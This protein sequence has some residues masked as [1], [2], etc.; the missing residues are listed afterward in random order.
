MEKVLLELSVAWPGLTNGL[1]RMADAVRLFV[2]TWDP[3]AGILDRTS[4]FATTNGDAADLEIVI[5]LPTWSLVA[6][7]AARGS[8][9]G[10]VMGAMAGSSIVTAARHEEAVN[11]GRYPSLAARGGVP[12]LLSDL[13]AGNALGPAEIAAVSVEWEPIGLGAITDL[14]QHAYGPVDLDRS[15]VEFAAVT[16][17]RRGCPA[18]AGRRF[19]FPGELATARDALCP[20][21]LQR[22]ES[23]V[24]QRL[25]RANASNPAGWHAITD[26]SLRLDRPHL[27]NGLA[28][29]LP[30]ADASIGIIAAPDALAERA[31][32]VVEA[33]GW[34]RG[35][36]RDFTQALGQ[37]PALAGQ[38]PDWLANLI[39]DLGRAG[40]GSD[41]E[42][43][44]DALGQ[45]DPSEQASFDGDVCVALAE[46]GLADKARQRIAAALARWPDELWIRVN[47]GEALSALGDLQGAEEHFGAALRMTDASDDFEARADVW[48][49]LRMATRPAPSGPHGQSG[50][51]RPQ[52]K[53]KL[54]KAQRKRKR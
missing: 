46:S 28:S 24:N 29:R 13:E 23:L 54:S 44:G 6:Q 52:P 36:A 2:I 51:Q 43:V 25:A 49:R 11:A 17:A 37:E 4:G 53:R 30:S 48:H 26:A 41:A 8:T 42:R 3:L 9:F 15:P 47:A 32:A 10:A 18:C 35:R 50:G 19:G 27:P 22:A 39:L 5:Y 33:A 45:V 1:A 31:D 20:P 16:A 14:A 38:L 40:L 7:A 34:F 21:H 12:D